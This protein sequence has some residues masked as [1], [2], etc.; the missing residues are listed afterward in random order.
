LSQDGV[1][2]KQKNG[3]EQGNHGAM[4]DEFVSPLP[5][6]KAG[7]NPPRWKMNLILAF[8]FKKKDKNI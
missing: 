3:T 7:T 4:K 1:C 5:Q 8:R 2:S 6:R